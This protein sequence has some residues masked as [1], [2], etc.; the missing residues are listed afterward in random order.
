MVVNLNN[1]TIK[2]LERLLKRGGHEGEQARQVLKAAGFYDIDIIK[3]D[4]SDEERDKNGRF[5][6][7]GG[8][9]GS[10]AKEP[11][12]HH[13]F[14]GNLDVTA[15]A[16]H[17]VRIDRAAAKGDKEANSWRES[18]KTSPFAARPNGAA[19]FESHAILET[20]RALGAR[21]AAAMYR[22][23][24][25]HKEVLDEADRLY[26]RKATKADP[27]PW[28]KAEGMYLAV[29]G[30]GR[31]D[32]ARAFSGFSLGKAADIFPYGQSRKK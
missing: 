20:G 19:A 16:E 10:G 7:G 12:T 15:T 29:K 18:A 30:A 17:L 24:A 4:V 1:E 32:P 22:N 2:Y 6:S 23:G 9:G 27:T 21:T 8:G 11:S 26:A 5:A 28:Y 13:F 31:P 25:T 14:N 3:R